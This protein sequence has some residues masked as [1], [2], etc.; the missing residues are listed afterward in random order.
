[1]Q[2]QAELTKIANDIKAMPV[3]FQAGF[4]AGLQ[5]QELEKQSAIDPRLLGAG[6]GALGGGLGG[7]LLAPA[8]SA[9]PYA[10]LGALGG[11]GV[12]AGGGHLLS[13]AP[14]TDENDPFMMRAR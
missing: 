11:A 9:L 6:I 10:A 13:G 5:G 4:I 1:M 2:K 14:I 7:A 3:A 8:G 12:G